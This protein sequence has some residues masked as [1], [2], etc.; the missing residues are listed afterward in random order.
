[1]SVADDEVIAGDAIAP[2]PVP[3]AGE[4]PEG[5]VEVHA[6]YD[7]HRIS[8]RYNTSTRALTV[9]SGP[10][11]GVYGAP[12]GAA[13]AVVKALNPYINPSRNGWSFWMITATGELLQSI[14]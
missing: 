5:E 13:V 1:M 6:T 7:G 14:R 8:G 9:M 3:E 4:A 2:S 11:Q 12:S 10:D